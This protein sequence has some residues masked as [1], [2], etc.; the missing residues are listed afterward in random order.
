MIALIVW[1]LR[2]FQCCEKIRVRRH[3][4]VPFGD[5]NRRLLREYKISP[6]DISCQGLGLRLPSG[7]VVLQD[8]SF[9]F[10]RGTISAIMGPS[11]SGKTTLLTTLAGRASY[12]IPSGK[13][14]VNGVSTALTRL[15]KTIG[16]VPQED[17]MYREMTV[18]ETLQFSGYSRLDAD[19]GLRE[20]AT[21]INSTVGLLGLEAVSESLIGDENIRGISGGQRKRVNLGIELVSHP[22]ILLLDEPTSGLD[23][24][25]S[26]EMLRALR[27]LAEVELTI[28]AIV[29]QPSWFVIFTLNGQFKF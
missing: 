23:S 14:L 18:R 2:R 15:K 3:I 10:P 16:F 8:V 19:I 12:G 4:V 5:D 29:H 7:K 24:A 1:L 22:T 6:K 25:A 27:E 28:V 11:G 17:V 26:L 20:K 21:I 9:T 13:I